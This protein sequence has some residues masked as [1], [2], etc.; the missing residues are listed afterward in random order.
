M[1]LTEK[2]TH[3]EDAQGN[4]ISQFRRRPNLDAF[5]NSYVQEMAD[6]ESMLFDLLSNTL[7]IGATTGANQDILGALV[8]E[9][10][11]NKSD[12]DY[13]IAISVR[14]LLNLSSATIEDLIGIVTTMIGG[15][16][17]MQVTEAFPAEFDITIDDPLPID[18]DE[19]ASF[20]ISAKPA[21]VRG[22]FRWFT[23]TSGTEFRFGVSGQGFDQGFL[24]TAS[25][26]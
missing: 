1:T 5:I 7:T 16:L 18:G 25:G 8:G 17:T 9:A 2:T 6:A 20:V 23:A 11:Q 10:R 13:D 22:L 24:G 15:G 14:I 19:V 26:A 21:G 4:L 12:A 3:V